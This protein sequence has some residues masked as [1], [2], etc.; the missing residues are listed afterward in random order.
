MESDKIKILLA[1]DEPELLDVAGKAFEKYFTVLS[2]ACGREALELLSANEVDCIILDIEMPGMSGIAMLKKLR[3][4]GDY[5]PVIITTGKSCR[6]YAEK[7]ADLNVHGYITK[8]YLPSALA[9]RIKTMITIG[10][11]SPKS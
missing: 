10:G 11:N 6:A 3:S 9:E 4:S 2:A 5:T 1:D 8:P 7:A